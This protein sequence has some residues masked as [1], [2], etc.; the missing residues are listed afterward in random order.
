MDWLDAVA[1]VA[2]LAGSTALRHYRTDLAVTTKADGSPVSIADLEAE[3]AARYWI[4]QYFPGD[5]IVGEEEGPSEPPNA[6]HRWIIDPIDGTLSF[7]RGVPLWG[8]MIGVMSGDNVLAGAVFFPALDELI[9]A[10]DS[11]GCWHNGSRCSV[12]EVSNLAEA[13]ILTTDGR[14]R[15]NADRQRKWAALTTRAALVRTWGDCYGYLLVATG[16]AEVMVDNRLHIWDYAPLVPIVR[17]A[18]GIITDWRGN[19]AFGGDA[20][21]TNRLL[22]DD[23]RRVLAEPIVRRP[24]R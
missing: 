20:I 22:A 11:A 13:T 16:R 15:D 9:V 8:T 14:F 21:A 5:A 24:P 23:V 3:R 19:A 6:A 10:A 7:I 2:R 4:N 18:G 17:E 1:E 12:S